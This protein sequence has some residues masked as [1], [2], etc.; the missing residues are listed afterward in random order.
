MKTITPSAE[1]WQ[2]PEDWHEHVAR[3]ARVCY[4]SE[5][6]SLTPEAFCDSLIKKGHLS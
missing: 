1:L 4:A 2:Q 3:C 6:G 5:T